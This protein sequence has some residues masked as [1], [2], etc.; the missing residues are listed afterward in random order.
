MG[1]NP[2]RGILK[3]ESWIG[4]PE[5]GISNESARRNPWDWNPGRGILKEE[6]WMRNPEGGIS[7]ESSL[8]NP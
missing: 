3:E 2:G 8:R 4:N 1:C 7:K 6:S 5:R